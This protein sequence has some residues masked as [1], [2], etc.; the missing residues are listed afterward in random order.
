M[1][2][3]IHT[4]PTPHRQT[5]TV[6]PDRGDWGAL[7]AELHSRCADQDLA[8][9]W[10]ELVAGERRAL[11]ASARLVERDPR[12]AIHDLPKASRDA[13]RAAIHRM[14]QYAGQLRDGLNGHRP[15]KSRELAAHARQALA[16]GN[17]EAALHWLAIIERGVE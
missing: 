5:P 7:R 17:T 11:L 1:P 9:L 6:E 3:Q 15:H 14:S 12:L 10:A 2:A 8:T 13:L 4:L 16:E